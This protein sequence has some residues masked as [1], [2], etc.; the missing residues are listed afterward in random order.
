MAEFLQ[1]DEQATASTPKASVVTQGRASTN[2]HKCGDQSCAVRGLPGL[3][4]RRGVR[5]ADGAV[6][7]PHF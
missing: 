6:S 2:P 3:P 5:E 4:E 7:A 1:S